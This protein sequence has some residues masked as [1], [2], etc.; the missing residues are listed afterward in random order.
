MAKI[1]NLLPTGKKAGGMIAHSK[2]QAALKKKQ[3]RTQDPL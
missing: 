2:A 1:R 3:E